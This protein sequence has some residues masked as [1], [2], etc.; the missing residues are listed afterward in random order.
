MLTFEHL[1]AITYVRLT[2]KGS[3]TTESITY[4]SYVAPSMRQAS[5]ADGMTISSSNTSCALLDYLIRK[6][7]RFSCN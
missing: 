5:N 2:E 6:V 4:V 3:L 1:S 7:P